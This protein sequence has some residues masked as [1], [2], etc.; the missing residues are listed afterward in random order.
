MF[1]PIILEYRLLQYQL[2]KVLEEH[3]SNLDN[4]PAQATERKLTRF[5][6]L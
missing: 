3:S 5:N 2:V 6:I 4:L 1:K